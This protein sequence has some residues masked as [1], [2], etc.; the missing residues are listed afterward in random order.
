MRSLLAVLLL[1]CSLFANAEPRAVAT[2]GASII[3]L[4]DE[5]CVVKAVTNLPH[6]ATWDENG[7]RF[8]GCF[9]AAYGVVAAYFDDGSVVLVPIQGFVEVK[10]L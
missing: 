5:P 7:K 1:A 4:Y 2:N 9:D 3:T 10:A 8:E 6:R